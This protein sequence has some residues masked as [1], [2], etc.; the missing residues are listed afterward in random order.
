MRKICFLGLGSNEPTNCY[1]LKAQAL[2]RSFFPDIVF[3]RIQRTV[4]VDFINDKLFFNQTARC[5][6]LLSIED[7]TAILKQTEKKLGRRPKDKQSG[8]VRIDIDLLIYDGKQLKTKEL[9]RHDII[10]GLKR[11]SQ[12]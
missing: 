8:I 11:L 9:Q 5:S 6:T 4:P 7:M 2:L 10:E 12:Y 3:D 1:I